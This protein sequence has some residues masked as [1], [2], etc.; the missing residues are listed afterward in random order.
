[1]NEYDVALLAADLDVREPAAAD[2]AGR[3][4]IGMLMLL[5]LDAL[6]QRDARA[7]RARADAHQT[8]FALIGF[9]VLEAIKLRLYGR[10]LALPRRRDLAAPRAARAS[11]A[12][13]RSPRGPRPPP[14]DGCMLGMGGFPM[15]PTDPWTAAAIPDLSGKTFIVTGGNSGLGFETARALARRGARVVIA[16]RNPEKASAAIAR[17]RA[18]NPRAGRRARW[19]S[20]SRASPRCAPSRG[21]PRRTSG[22]CTAWSTTPA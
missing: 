22:A 3:H 15:P 12:A 6:R 14:A 5:R 1:M 10:L 13:A 16:C 4:A 11:A 8:I 2:R 21:V 18:E 19:R 9:A 20:T 17:L 7:R